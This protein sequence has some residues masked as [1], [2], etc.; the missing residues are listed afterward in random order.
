MNAPIPTKE[1]IHEAI[2]RLHPGQLTQLWEY[3]QTLATEQ[4]PTKPAAPLYR[5]YEQA[6]STGMTDL[7]EHHDDY[8]YGCGRPDA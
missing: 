8:L 2:D 6:I 5:I 4:A 7:A 1:Q 3:V